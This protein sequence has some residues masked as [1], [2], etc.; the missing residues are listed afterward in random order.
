MEHFESSRE[1]ENTK[2]IYENL[3]SDLISGN[4]TLNELQDKL[5]ELDQSTLSRDAAEDNLKFLYDPEIINYIKENPDAIIGY[6]RFLSFTEFHVA[7]RIA[8]TN[9]NEAI[10]HF[11]KSLESARIDQS[12][13]GWL[14]YV[15]GTL[16]YMEGREIP[17]EII[18]QAEQIPQNA[19][20]L[21]HFNAKLAEKGTPSYEEDYGKEN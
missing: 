3:K 16:L 1:P 9:P 4:I 6:H 12:E 8:G 2:N 21:K 10:N 19:T 20:I 5:L 11:K 7:Q 13:K 15:E 18:S 14:A 17:N